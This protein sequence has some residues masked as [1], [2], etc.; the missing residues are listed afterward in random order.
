MASLLEVAL[1]SAMAG[2]IAGGAY[3]AF[4]SSETMN[5]G[6]AKGAVAGVG[7][8][9]AAV[10]GMALKGGVDKALAKARPAAYGRF[11]KMKA[12]KGINAIKSTLK[13]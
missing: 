10:G 5:S 2:T 7:L 11:A 3:G 12:N 8:A 1:G 9:G 4:S 13:F 6:A